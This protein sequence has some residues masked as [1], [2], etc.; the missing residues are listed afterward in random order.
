MC[1]EGHHELQGPWED[2]DEEVLE[3]LEVTE[4]AMLEPEDEYRA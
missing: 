2:M 4:D 1:R 3:S